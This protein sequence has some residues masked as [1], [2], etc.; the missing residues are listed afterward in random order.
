MAARHLQANLLFLAGFA[1]MAAVVNLMLTRLPR[2]RDESVTPE[3]A[4]GGTFHIN[5]T[6]RQLDAAYRQAAAGSVPD[7][8]PCEIYCHTLTD[9][10]ILSQELAGK[11]YHTLTL[12][13]LDMP[14]SLFT[15]D[16][17][18]TR[19]EAP[20]NM[21]APSET[22]APTMAKPRSVTPVF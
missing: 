9:P 22:P 7:P 14:Y 21:G 3:Q 16:N 2:L 6:Y 18:G 5:E 8:L 4:F 19:A 15:E 1:V 12:F 11:G 13:G 10:S 17:P 20:Y